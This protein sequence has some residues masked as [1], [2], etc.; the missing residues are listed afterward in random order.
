MKLCLKIIKWSKEVSSNSKDKF[1]TERNLILKKEML[2]MK[3]KD[4]DNYFCVN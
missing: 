2:L 3:F 1:L 4:K